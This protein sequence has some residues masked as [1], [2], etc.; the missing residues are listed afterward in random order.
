[1]YSSMINFSYTSLVKSSN[2]PS[3][4]LVD[5]IIRRTLQYKFSTISLSIIV[6]DN[7]TSQEY[8]LQYRNKNMPTNVISLEYYEQREQFNLLIGELI[9]AEEVILTEA[10]AQNKNVINHYVHM[11]VHGLLHLQG[12]DHQIDADAEEM[13]ALEV[14]IMKSLGY[15]NP[16]L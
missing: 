16:Y 9:L 7:V 14:I 3:R 2:R 5:K 6:V 11:L 12:Y 4:N 13:E 10:L 8:N 15:S 1:M